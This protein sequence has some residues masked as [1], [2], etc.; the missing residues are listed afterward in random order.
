MNTLIASLIARH[1][2]KDLRL[3]MVDPKM[4]EMAAYNPLPHMACEVVTD[5]AVEAKAKLDGLVVEMED[6]YQKFV[7]SETSSLEQYNHYA[8][9][10]NLPTLPLI[11]VIIDEYNDL[12]NVAP[13]I[14]DLV[15][16]LAQKSRAAGIHLVIATQR[17]TTNVITGSIKNNMATIVALRVAKQVDSVTM[18][19]H[20]GAEILGGNGDMYLV[21]PL[22]ARYGEIRVQGAFIHVD[23]INRICAFLKSKYMPDYAE[24]FL[25]LVDDD[26]PSANF[27]GSDAGGSGD[28]GD[29]PLYAVIKAAA[30][31]QEFV[32]MSWISRTYNTGY[33][34]ALKIFKQL[35]VE[36]IIDASFDNPN[37]NRGRKVLKKVD[38]DD[39]D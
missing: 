17:P 10:Q 12:I 30:M 24:R 28:T 3:I 14:S 35:Q 9:E 18:L 6:R 39:R 37:N 33:P 34:R 29:D 4:V 15:Q 25:N 1:S 20:A 8:S 21:N 26:Q 27:Q 22:F 38:N 2:A 31:A 16:R 11:F 13:Q 19:G 5:A 32:S 23:E 7:D 36:G